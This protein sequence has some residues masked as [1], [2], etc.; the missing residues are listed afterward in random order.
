MV[1]ET[2]L[3]ITEQLLIAVNA[4]IKAGHSIM[5]IYK[6]DFAVEFKKDASPLTEADKAADK[7]IKYFLGNRYPVLSE[8]GKTISFEERKKWDIFWLI[9][10]LDGTKEF[11]KKNGEFT[12]NIALIEEN[13]PILGVVYV[14]ASSVLYFGSEETGSFFR[15]IKENDK[16]ETIEELI[17]DSVKMEGGQL[18]GKYTVV[19]SRSHTSPETEKFIA[20]CISEHEEIEIINSGSSI[21]FCLVAEGKAHVYP[22]IAPTMEWDTAA[23]HAVA[24]FSGCRVVDFYTGEELKYNKEN[25]LN[26]HFLVTH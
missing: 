4:A 12:V 24:K 16:F 5:N 11:I 22:R 9:D 2:G 23:A 25:L 19:A 6:K 15:V 8:E 10:P 21:K 13:H 14:P 20:Q 18:P 7:V 1:N 26:P 3:T 17:K